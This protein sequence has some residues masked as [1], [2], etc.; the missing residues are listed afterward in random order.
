MISVNSIKDVMAV[1]SKRVVGENKLGY[2]LNPVGRET[3][4]KYVAYVGERVISTAASIKKS[5]GNNITISAKDLTATVKAMFRP[6]DAAVILGTEELPGKVYMSR[7][8]NNVV[9]PTAK[10]IM[11]SEKVRIPAASVVIIKRA[12]LFAALEVCCEFARKAA[13]AVPESKTRKTA[14]FVPDGAFEASAVSEVWA[15]YG[16]FRG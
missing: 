6:E 16:Q 7:L 10:K 14:A 1:A 13:A 4:S 3:V 2:R 5:I 12:M 11:E 15:L 9:K 8:T